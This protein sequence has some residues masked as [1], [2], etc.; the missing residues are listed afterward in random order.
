MFILDNIVAMAIIVMLCG[1]HELGM[2]LL[3]VKAG[4]QADGGMLS[5]GDGYAIYKPFSTLHSSGLLA[6]P[7][8]KKS[9]SDD[10]ACGLTCM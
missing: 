10:I 3:L 1:L 2:D 7:E 9:C 4:Q 8:G 6:R 5:I